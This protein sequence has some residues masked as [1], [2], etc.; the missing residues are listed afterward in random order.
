MNFKKRIV[1]GMLMVTMLLGSMTIA[2]AET[3]EV[4][5][6]SQQVIKSIV[7][8]IG[9]DTYY[10]NGQTPGVK[11]DAAP[12]IENDRTYV[13]VRFLGNALG[14]KDDNIGWEQSTQKV[15]LSYKDI[16]A[17][18]AIGSKDI[19][20][21][22]VKTVMDVAPQIK[23]PG[24][25]FLPARYVAEA[26]GYEVDWQNGKYVVI[27]PTG[28]DKP[29]VEIV[30]E[31]IEQQQPQPQQPPAGTTTRGYVIPAKTDLNVGFPQTIEISI[32]VG[33]HM[34]RE[35]QYVDLANIL[36][37]K[38]NDNL[39]NEVVAYVKTKTERNQGLELK[40][41]QSNGRAIEALSLAGEMGIN[42][43]VR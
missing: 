15:T 3:I 14:V 20:S 18:M 37:S 42:V 26:L 38:F 36:K 5:D 31:Y 13:P 12:F 23:P 22:S 29:N 24:R 33:L 40:K 43:R 35:A 41:W 25:T 9:K 10:V 30:K 34:P 32:L 16:V 19:Y 1:A 17:S 39:A 4:Q 6:E 28:S 8:A 11:M 27:W 21:N 2:G 7:F